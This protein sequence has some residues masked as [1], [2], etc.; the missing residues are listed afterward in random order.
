MTRPVDD[1]NLELQEAKRRVRS[2]ERELN[3]A[4]IEAAPFAVGDVVE[5]ET[6]GGRGWA[7]ALVRDV[8]PQGTWACW[9]KVSLRKK[10]GDWSNQVVHA[11]DKVRA[12]DRD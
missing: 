2:L 10:D 5:A 3:D 11:F 12:V 1:I 4:L 6:G 9:F 7:E 8:E